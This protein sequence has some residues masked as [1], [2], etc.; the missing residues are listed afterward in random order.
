VIDFG[1]G[2]KD[3]PRAGEWV[4]RVINA[5]RTVLKL[6]RSSVQN[7]VDWSGHGVFFIHIEEDEAITLLM[8]N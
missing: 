3:T 2:V 8:K 6:V 1:L 5:L 7:L 4:G